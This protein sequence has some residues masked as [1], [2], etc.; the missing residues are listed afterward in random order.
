MRS[1]QAQAMDWEPNAVGA[2]AEDTANCKERPLEYSLGA[3]VLAQGILKQSGMEQGLPIFGA[4]LEA[5][6]FDTGFVPITS[7][8][9]ESNTLSSLLPAVACASGICTGKIPGCRPPEGHMFRIERIHFNLSRPVHWVP[10]APFMLRDAVAFGLSLLPEA[11]HVLKIHAELAST[12]A[13]LEWAADAL[14]GVESACFDINSPGCAGR[15][16]NHVNGS[17]V[18]SSF[19]IGIHTPLWHSVDEGFLTILMKH[20]AFDQISDGL[21]SKLGNIQVVGFSIDQ[22]SLD[23]IRSHEELKSSDFFGGTGTLF[24]LV[25]AVVVASTFSLDAIYRRHFHSTRCREAD[26][27]ALKSVDPEVATGTRCKSDTSYTL[28]N[29]VAT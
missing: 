9:T 20:Q 4:L 14:L 24:V 28:V 2:L 25:M 19:T 13:D 29:T 5:P 16:L 7:A 23:P 1:L 17:H 26:V 15:R 12:A 18:F 21:E 27:E 10:D 6:D 3:G 11:I 22:D 8:S